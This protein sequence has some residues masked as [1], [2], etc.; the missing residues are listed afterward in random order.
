M[1]SG[2][3]ATAPFDLAVG[4]CDARTSLNVL[5]PAELCIVA[6]VSDDG[7]VLISLHLIAVGPITVCLSAAG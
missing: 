2:R 3:I 4:H 1:A 6:C 7:D 5:S